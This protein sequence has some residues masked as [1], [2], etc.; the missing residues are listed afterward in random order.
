MD[1]GIQAVDG[2]LDLLHALQ[3]LPARSGP[4]ITGTI[5]WLPAT[6]A[7]LALLTPQI[8]AGFTHASLG[9]S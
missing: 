2:R 9:G 8:P 6:P 5:Q 1:G 3:S 7:N 4:T